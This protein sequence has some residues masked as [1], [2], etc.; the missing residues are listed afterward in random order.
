MLRMF[1][2]SR[3]TVMT[4]EAGTLDLRMVD[5]CHGGEVAG[6]MAVLADIGCLNMRGVL[7]G[8][9]RAVMATDAVAADIAVIEPTGGPAIGGMT[10]VAGIDTRDMV[11]VFIVCMTVSA[12]TGY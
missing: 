10:V 1:A 7:A 12:G 5:S 6:V 2:G 3:R 11:S 8:G 9:R 4:T